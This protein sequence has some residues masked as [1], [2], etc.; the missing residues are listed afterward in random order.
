MRTLLRVVVVFGLTAA[1]A[2]WFLSAPTTLSDAQVAELGEGD[3]DHGETVYWAS[4]CTSCHSAPGAKGNDKLVLGGGLRLETPFGVF[5]APN[6]SQ[7]PQ[8][9]IGGWSLIDFANAMTHGTSPDGENYYPAFPYAS[10]ARMD[11]SDVGDLYAFMKTLPA[12]AGKATEN[13]LS[14][15]FNVRRGVGLWK[16]LFLSSE[17]VVAA[18]VGSTDV[19]PALWERGRYL[20]EGPGHCAECHTPRDFAGGLKLAKWL[21]G[22]PAATGE[23]RVPNITPVAGGFGNWSANDIAYYLESGFTPDYD[24]VGGEMVSVQDNMSRLPA[25]DRAAI[26]SYLKAIPAVSPSAQ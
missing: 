7:D 22:A 20:V 17:P 10:Y 6:I 1:V 14:F 9:G 13:E 26:A 5:V 12:V 24:S 15:P 16:R 3:S 19:D 2:S 18:P 21:G 23:G 11:L 8:D 4:G 25:E